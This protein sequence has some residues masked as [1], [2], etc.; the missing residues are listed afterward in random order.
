MNNI[1]LGI[2]L[3]T[4]VSVVGAAVYFVFNMAKQAKLSREYTVRK[5]RIEQMSQII[6]DFSGILEMGNEIILHLNRSKADPEVY[7]SKK[8]DFT[9]FCVTVDS[10]IRIKQ[11]LLFEVWATV[12]DKEIINNIQSLVLEWNQTWYTAA[13]NQDK[14]NV[15]DFVELNTKI[16]D[17]VFELS[18]N[19]RKQVE[20]SPIF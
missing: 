3:A 12:D 7:D 1:Q 4:S 9:E 20:E 16:G 18:L 13:I 6:S 2:D 5:Q 10:Y 17:K 11:K 8:A 15:P 14:E 19:L